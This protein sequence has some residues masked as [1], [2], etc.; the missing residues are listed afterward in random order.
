MA[1]ITATPVNSEEDEVTR[2]KRRLRTLSL[3]DLADEAGFLPGGT[4]ED[5]LLEA[6]IARR[7]ALLDELLAAGAD[8][9][10]AFGGQ[11]PSSPMVDAYL[12]MERAIQGAQQR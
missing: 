10:A 4:R 6:E 12:R 9:L 2:Y 5:E 3:Q 11:R 8:M 1:T 7:Q